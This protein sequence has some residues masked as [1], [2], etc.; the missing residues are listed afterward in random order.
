MALAAHK[1]NIELG[2]ALSGTFTSSLDRGKEKLGTLGT[3]IRN[4]DVQAKAANAFVKLKGETD[5]AKAAWGAAEKQMQTL[6]IEIKKTTN[7]TKELSDKF[8][9]AQLTARNAK[10]AYQDKKQSLDNLSE[11]L[12]KAGMNT[13]QLAMS[14]TKLGASVAALKSRY[15]LMQNLMK[16]QSELAQKAKAAMGSLK[17]IGATTAALFGWPIKKAIDAKNA[18]TTLGKVVEVIRPEGV[19]LL[20]GELEGLTRILPITFL[21]LTKLATRGARLGIKDADLKSWTEVVGKMAVVFGMNAD[22]MGESVAKLQGAFGLATAD[23]EHVGDVID[24][25]GSTSRI[26]SAALI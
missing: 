19:G 23:L 2:A 20:R 16:Q 9:E 21:E 4:L 6:G 11:S 12:K 25:L 18:M 17:K 26:E 3:A 5:K 1:F 14:Q 13:E 22:E 8:K 15:A 24:Y 10:L 7:P